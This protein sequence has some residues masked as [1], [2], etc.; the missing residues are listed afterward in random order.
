MTASQLY[1]TYVLLMFIL[2]YNIITRRVSRR[3]RE[4]YSGHGRLSVCPLPDSCTTAQIR[5]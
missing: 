4:M 3:L 5:M 1:L 2:C